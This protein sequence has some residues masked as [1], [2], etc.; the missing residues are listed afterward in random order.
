MPWSRARRIKRGWLDKYQYD[1]ED[2]TAGPT[3]TTF[4]PTIAETIA[5]TTFFGP[6]TDDIEAT[7][8]AGV[9]HVVGGKNVPTK[10]K[11][12]SNKK[13]FIILAV[14]AAILVLLIAAVVVMI[15]FVRKRRMRQRLGAKLDE[16]ERLRQER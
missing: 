3:I 5:N 13:L 6:G 12:L 16:E 1:E 14:A 9:A 4:I 11:A 10:A 15:I 2:S 7:T 8:D